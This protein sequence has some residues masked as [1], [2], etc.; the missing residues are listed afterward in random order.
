MNIEEVLTLPE[1][2]TVEFKR[3]FSSPVN[4][5]RSVIAFANTSGG[6][7]I[8]GVED[9]T[10]YIKGIEEPL[11]LEEKIVNVISDTIEPTVIPDL[12]IVP[13][14]GTYLIVLHV[15]PSSSRPHYYSKL[16]AEKGTYVRVGSTNRIA[17]S[18]MISELKRYARS[19][20]F[21]EQP[22]IDLDSEAIDFRVASEQ[23]S[24]TRKLRKSDLETLDILKNYQDRL[25]PS[26]GGF[27]LFGHEREKYFPDAW[28]QA[29]RFSGKNKNKIQD[30]KSFKSHLIIAVHD[31]IGFI[32]KHAQ[33]S[34]QIDNVR[35]TKS[36]T[37]PFIAIR[38]AV[39]NAVVHADY[40]QKG[41]PIRIAIMDDRIE[42]DNPGLLYFGLTISDIKS[43]I[44]KLRNR[45]IGRIFHS[46]GLIERW[47]S[48]IQ[49]IISSCEDG[50]FPT[51]KFEELGSHFRVTIYTNRVNA[52][53][54]QDAVNEEIL[55]YLKENP[56]GMSTA[57]IAE[58]ISLS[59][60][61]TRTRLLKLIDKGFVTELASSSQDPNRLYFLNRTNN[62]E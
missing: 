29:G 11:V 61:A 7:L 4:I 51:P 24:E 18:D 19:Q 6:M 44:S 58:K 40:S 33:Q 31:A 62:E 48:G 2:K 12:E 1:G 27:L 45:V 46:I 21:D 56:K 14:R 55:R 34:I 59:T 15:H 5:I 28:I 42:I 49:R 20:T 47:G 39:I 50:G 43:G 41:S 60:R 13:W 32:K 57:A 35:H 37:V 52:I 8:L 53:Q 16:G 38:E 54:Q 25:V 36:W 9:K 26:I 10:H 23:F 17:C 3:D 22:M 30:S